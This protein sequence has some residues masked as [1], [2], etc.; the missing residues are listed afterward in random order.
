MKKHKQRNKIYVN[1]P[2]NLTMF[3]ACI[4]L[5]LAIYVL[6]TIATKKT[7]PVNNTSGENQSAYPTTNPAF[8]NSSLY[9]LKNPEN[10]NI[11]LNIKTNK[12]PISGV[13]LA[14]AYDPKV[15]QN[16]SITPG[17]FFDHPVILQNAVDATNGIVYYTLAIN[18]N[19]AQISGEGTVA[20]LHYT[21]LAAGNSTKV[22]FL[23]QT[24]VTSQGVNDSVLKQA[25][26]IQLP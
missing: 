20:V 8:I 13:Q 11:Y 17:D 24:K 10:N 19:S 16:V 15:L 21:G 18:P 5:L 22:S 6:F 4:A 14:I 1:S 12:Q 26:A 23:P 9:I 3:V 7:S 25:N 2:K